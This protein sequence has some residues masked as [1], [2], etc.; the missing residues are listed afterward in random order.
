M[1]FTRRYRFAASHRLHTDA[2]SKDEN[3]SL[4]GKCN[5][6]FGHGHDY[7]LSVTVAGPV[8][9]RTGLIVHALLLDE[10]VEQRVL[11]HLA[12]RNLNQDVSQLAERVPTTENVAAVI[13]TLLREHWTGRFGEQ[14]LLQLSRVH[15]Q[16]TARNGF[17]IRLPVRTDG[18]NRVGQIESVAVNAQR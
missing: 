12:H 16:E 13:S 7:M 9:K 4:F 17:E 5:N 11:R 15:L 3:A 2:L 6:P 8:D 10:F 1:E 18:L 14:T